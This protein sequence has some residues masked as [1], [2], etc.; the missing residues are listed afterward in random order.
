MAT[1][2]VWNPGQGLGPCP[3]GAGEPLCF[4]AGVGGLGHGGAKKGMEVVGPSG[5]KIFP[6]SRGLGAWCVCFGHFG[7]AMVGVGGLPWVPAP[8]ENSAPSSKV[9]LP[10]KRWLSHP[11]RSAALSSSLTLTPLSLPP[12]GD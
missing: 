7:L 11:L 4:L 2:P 3:V 5:M 6:I 9:G 10:Y 8:S 12:L 1:G